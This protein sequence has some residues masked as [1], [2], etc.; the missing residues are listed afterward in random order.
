MT[1]SSKTIDKIVDFN[2]EKYREVEMKHMQHM[3]DNRPRRYAGYDRS[4]F[5][6][7]VYIKQ[8]FAENFRQ[9]WFGERH[10]IRPEQHW[11]E[12]DIEQHRRG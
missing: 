8:G 2:L 9:Y 6:A 11:G 3:Y 12:K 5:M 7:E 4:T 10:L 1:D